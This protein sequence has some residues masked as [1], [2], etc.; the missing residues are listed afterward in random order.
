MKL[1]RKSAIGM[2]IG[3]ALVMM[4]GLNVVG[5]MPARAQDPSPQ[6]IN[7]Y[8][9]VTLQST[10]GMTTAVNG[11]AVDVGSFGI[12]DCY[13]TFVDATATQTLTEKIQHSADGTYW[14]DLYSF[15]AASSTSTVF[16][17]TAVLGRY[18]RSVP[19]LG[20]TAGLTFTVK[21]LLKNN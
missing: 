19:A 7:S 3:L 1:N 4:L 10:V 11:S 20:T 18:F 5:A 21:C 2:L 8:R 17:R 12:A 13:S 16:T 9:L 14:V 6:S 15:S